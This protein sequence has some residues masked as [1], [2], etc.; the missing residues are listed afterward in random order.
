MVT[1]TSR[2]NRVTPFGTF[3]RTPHRG[4][5]LGNRGDLHD[6]TGRIVKGW[7]GTRWI[8]CALDAGDGFRVTFDT[9][10]HYTPLFFADEAV[11]LAAGH[12]PCHQCRRP[13]FDRFVAAWAHSHDAPERKFRVTEIDP[14]LHAA[15]LDQAGHHRT[16]RARFGDLPDGAFY[17]ALLDGP[18]RSKTAFLQ[19]GGYAYPFSHAG[20]GNPLLVQPCSVVD[21]LTS[22]PMIAILR[23]GYVPTVDLLALHRLP[24]PD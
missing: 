5:L 13:A 11:A 4:T 12:R 10:G 8:S 21:V 7:R 9:P 18:G 16:H 15:R 17:H 23:A 1:T 20:Y 22:I 2:Q 24:R 14:E 6:R 19:W 3:E